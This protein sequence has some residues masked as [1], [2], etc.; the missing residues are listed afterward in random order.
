MIFFTQHEQGR[1][2][3]PDINAKGINDFYFGHIDFDKSSQPAKRLVAILDK[4]T[5]L[6]R[7]SKRPKLKA[8]DAIHLVMLVDALWDD[9]THSWEQKLPS[10]GQILRSFSVSEV[11]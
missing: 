4:I 9:Y 10:G 2:S 3:F 8:H 11:E 7:G 5:Q 6:L 1:N